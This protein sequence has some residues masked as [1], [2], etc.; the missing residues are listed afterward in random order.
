[1]IHPYPSLSPNNYTFRKRERDG[2]GANYVHHIRNII[3]QDDMNMWI[4]FSFDKF[5]W[6]LQSNFPVLSVRVSFVNCFCD[7]K[8]SLQ[9]ATDG[10]HLQL[11]FIE[12]SFCL[13][14]TYLWRFCVLYGR[15]LRHICSSTRL[16]S[17]LPSDVL[18]TLISLIL[19]GLT[20]FFNFFFSSLFFTKSL[21][22]SAIFLSR[23]VILRF[24]QEHCD[25]MWALLILQLCKASGGGGGLKNNQKIK[26]KCYWLTVK[27]Q[28]VFM[29]EG[30]PQPPKKQNTPSNP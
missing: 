20:S 17:H 12:L 2:E 25:P 23:D 5:L 10:K 13:L 15:T 18:R 7:W 30:Q 27:V 1:M 4:P 6:K 21:S 14:L 26:N 28:L 8:Q 22:I 3:I 29:R 19:V 24:N 9:D 11:W 16:I